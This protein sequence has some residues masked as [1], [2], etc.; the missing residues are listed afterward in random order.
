MTNLP[1]N[2]KSLKKHLKSLN[3]DQLESLYNEYKDLDSLEFGYIEDIYEEKLTKEYNRRQEKQ[4]YFTKLLSGE[5]KPFTI[6]KSEWDIEKTVDYLTLEDYTDNYLVLM[7][8]DMGTGKNFCFNNCKVPYKL[9]APLLSIVGQQDSD[10]N[11]RTQSI[12]TYDQ[13][14]NIL[15]LIEAGTLN[16]KENILVIDEAHNFMIAK[17][18]LSALHAVEKLLKYKWKQIIFQS[19]TV[20]SY[21]L[22]T[23][24]KFDVKIRVHKK[25]KPNIQ[26]KRLQ[27]PVL[28]D[29]FE[30][31][32]QFIIKNSE[33]GE[34]SIVLYNDKDKLQVLAGA[35][36]EFGLIVDIVDSDRTKEENT[37]A[38]KL[39]KDSEF[40]MDAIDVLVGTTSLV[41]GISIKDDI[42]AANAII[43]GEE[44]PEYIKQLC[45][46]FRKAKFINCL[47][48][49]ANSLKY[50][51]NDVDEWLDQKRLE[52]QIIYDDCEYLT[53]RYNKFKDA[54]HFAHLKV[55]GFNLDD[56][57]VYFDYGNQKYVQSSLSLLFQSSMAKKFQ[58][59][60]NFKY[61]SDVM[62][63]LGFNVVYTE[64]STSVAIIQDTI[65][66]SR[67][68]IHEG[69]KSKRNISAKP[70]VK[71]IQMLTKQGKKDFD[72]SLYFNMRREL[73]PNLDPFQER[74][75][76]MLFK[77]NA[78]KLSLLQ[79]EDIIQKMINGKMSDETILINTVAM[80]SEYGII[81]D[82]KNTYTTGTRLTLLE[83]NKVLSDIIEALIQLNV[84]ATGMSTDD[85]FNFVMKQD[86][87]L[88]SKDSF[89]FVN[90]NVI[91]Q[92]DRPS[93]LLKNY[94]PLFTQTQRKVAGVKVRMIEIL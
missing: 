19:A 20:G 45:G 76:D 56:H 55:S 68:R 58:F 9:L 44:Y 86:N 26:Y 27:M 4:N 83:Q 47:H 51:I 13:A 3:L 1:Q 11:V 74:I 94:L 73:L 84:N 41:E 28:N 42:I 82:L 30:E 25:D 32:I 12:T 39:A 40:K 65:K 18:R 63:D 72:L 57:G 5:Y 60:S 17:Y 87:W 53:T 77:V 62:T 16:T 50:Q 15:E 92:C 37:I 78:E 69:I 36:K 8:A 85:A 23:F 67:K 31:A 7:V 2:P 90:N 59:Y 80:L 29:C 35:L 38:Y 52:T 66:D 6:I 81:A 48:L 61:A 46:R 34:K 64:K 22:D 75:D 79:I 88:R 93:R 10:N 54:D 43:I 89:S 49:A 21:D 24:I 91:V 70:I 33:N 71:I 14:R